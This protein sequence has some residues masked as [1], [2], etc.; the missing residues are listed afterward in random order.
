MTD[1]KNKIA[2]VTGGSQGIGRAIAHALAGSGCRVIVNCA[3]NSA[4]AERVVAEIH[5]NGG[6]AEPLLCDV[7]DEAAVEAMFDHLESLGGAES[8]STT[9][10]SIRG[11]DAPA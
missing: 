7:S 8:S 10:V 6:L 3:H 2:L 9:P 5:D 1:L 4:N 11:R